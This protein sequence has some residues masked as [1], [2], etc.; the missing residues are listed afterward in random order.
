[1]SQ[2]TPSTTI[3]KNYILKIKSMV[4]VKKRDTTEIQMIIRGLLKKHFLIKWKIYETD[5]FSDTYDPP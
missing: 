2:C 1:M 4:Q 5:K 3:T